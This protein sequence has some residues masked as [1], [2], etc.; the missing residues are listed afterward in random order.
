MVNGRASL[1]F[2]REKETLNTM[3]YKEVPE[4]GGP[5]VVGSLYLRKDAYEAL[6]EPLELVVT[7]EGAGE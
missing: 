6:G 5:A 1:R 4:D 2:A 7:I 3:R